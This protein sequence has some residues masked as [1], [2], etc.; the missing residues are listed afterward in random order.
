MSNTRDEIYLGAL[1]HD[2]G[3]FY[4]RADRDY[5]SSNELG[6]QSKRIAQQI[7]PVTQAGYF[8][9]QHVIWT[10]EFFEQYQNMFQKFLTVKPGA[11][12]VA[13]LASYHHR[14]ATISQAII[15]LADWWA[16]GLDRSHLGNF[17]A[18]DI[19]TG[20]QRY[21]EIP[22]SNIL[23]ALRVKEKDTDKE[24][25]SAPEPLSFKLNPLS[26]QREMLMPSPVDLNSENDYKK[27][28][29]QF[30][31]KLTTSTFNTSSLQDFNITLFHLL[32]QF[33]WNIPSFTQENFPCISL[34]EHL[35][36]TSALAHCLYDF[37]C[38][39]PER[40]V[41]DTT[42][43][44]LKL[45]DEAFPVQLVCFDLSGIQSFLYNI[46]SA[47]A[48]KSLRGRS[49][50]IQMLVESLQWYL[51]KGIPD[52]FTPSHTVYA[53]GGK[54]F[55]L[56]PN[57]KKVNRIISDLTLRIQQ[58]LWENHKGELYLNT[59]K[60]AFRYDNEI[61][62]GRPNIRIE[63]DEKNVFLG[64]L[65]E[66]VFRETSH[67]DGQRF[68][69]LI[70]SGNRF[71]ELFEPSGAGG[72]ER[73]C[74][75]T[76]LEYSLDELYAFSEE[77]GMHK[78]V[79]AAKAGDLTDMTLIS[80]PVKQQIGLGKKLVNHKYIAFNTGKS[81]SQGEF[82]G[83]P[84]FS[85]DV[86]SSYS[87]EHSNSLIVQNFNEEGN[88]PVKV[89]GREQAF[90][91]R[92]FGGATVAMTDGEPMTFNEI[93]AANK[94]ESRFSRLGILRM[95][96]DNLGKLFIDGFK[97][98]DEVSSAEVARNASFSAYADFSGLLDLFFSGYINTIRESDKY[99]DKVNII[100][101][102]GD[103][104]FAIG[105]W[106]SIIDFASEVRKEFRHF[107]GR[108]DITLSA[109]IEIVTPKFPVSRAAENA[110]KAEAKAKNHIDSN[111]L[112]KNS[113][114][115]LDIPVNWDTEWP[116]VLEI[117]NK[118]KAWLEKEYI[119]KGLIM[120][121][122]RTYA[123]WK[124]SVE[125]ENKEDYSWKWTTAYSIAR[126][127]KNL[128]SNPDANRALEELKEILFTQIGSNRIRFDLLALACRLVELESRT[129][130]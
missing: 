62:A 41:F 126:R 113:L 35:K 76:G 88:F 107:T 83:L 18:I 81:S 128:S 60:A 115:I 84:D 119:T 17:E 32:K 120:F 125:F 42:R 43:K 61:N 80:E 33:T 65:W 10:N 112:L 39:D 79:N 105:R 4:Q 86:S 91:F 108:N 49:F 48:L 22:L 27:L 58:E 29:E 57:T 12:N 66:R 21:K 63:G 53:S 89:K 102:G 75:V 59:G 69:E 87:E 73:I 3:K 55:M 117:R 54:F 52:G 6:E 40:F 129:N 97:E 19:K 111:G 122:L 74:G 90:A 64:S 24:G 15:Q 8:S 121:L 9:H 104:L 67:N 16:S 116:A 118:M 103:D 28:W 30:V 92:Y 50:Y 77:A 109:G 25:K 123:K 100:Y 82:H 71:G 127:Q 20:R 130:K 38:E 37:Y 99:R 96:V 93:A 95:D 34:F 51:I 5:Y 14:P 106:D 31:S 78:W 47:N 110:G 101:S 1:L 56:L 23:G 114:C 26:F 2:I 72:K 7:C 11:D 70:T 13:N 44:R 45:A 36:I 94:E 46:S 68:A 98:W 85:Y 124:H